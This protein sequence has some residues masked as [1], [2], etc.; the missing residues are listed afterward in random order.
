VK[1]CMAPK[2]DMEVYLICQIQICLVHS[3][4][5]ALLI[6]SLKLVRSGSK[7]QGMKWKC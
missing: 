3:C 5:L 7:Y 2:S 1:C 6:C 4:P